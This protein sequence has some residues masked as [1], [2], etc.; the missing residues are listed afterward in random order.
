MLAR[1][2]AREF[3]N[4]KALKN[5]YKCSAE[6]VERFRNMIVGGGLLSDEEYQGLLVRFTRERVVDIPASWADLT[7]Q[8]LRPFLKHWKDTE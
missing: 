7:L 2:R 4:E 5:F 3:K 1:M 8:A 6:K